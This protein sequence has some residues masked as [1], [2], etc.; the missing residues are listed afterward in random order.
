MLLEQYLEDIGSAA[1]Q[2]ALGLDGPRPALVR[3]TTDP[4]FGDFQLNGAMKLGKELGKPPREL[5]QPIADVL[6]DV[7]AIEKA[8]GDAS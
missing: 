6:A 8:L 2:K 7:E 4:K 1:I 5:A 3:P